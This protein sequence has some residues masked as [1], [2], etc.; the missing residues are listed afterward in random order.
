LASAKKLVGRLRGLGKVG[1]TGNHIEAF[2]I[3]I[4]YKMPHYRIQVATL[5]AS[6]WII[7]NYGTGVYFLLNS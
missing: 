5:I 7:W 2:S 3:K 4:C 6:V 1:E